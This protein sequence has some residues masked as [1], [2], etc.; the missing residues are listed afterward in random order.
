MLVECEQPSFLDC[1][2][3]YTASHSAARQIVARIAQYTGADVDIRGLSFPCFVWLQPPFL[4]CVADHITSHAAERQIVNRLAPNTAAHYPSLHR[5]DSHRLC[6]LPLPAT[7][8]VS[9]AAVRCSASM[10]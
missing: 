2:A 1:V 10:L 9:T 3:E 4:A 7:W 8:A 6:W 5:G